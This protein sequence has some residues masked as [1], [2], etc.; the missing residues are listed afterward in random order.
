LSEEVRRKFYR[1]WYASKKRKAFTKYVNKYRG[2][3]KA[4]KVS[5]DEMKRNGC[6]IRV[7]CHTQVRLVPGL[8]GKKPQLME[9]EVL[10]G[11]I[12]DK[13]TF[14]LNLLEKEVPVDSTF[15]VTDLVDVIAISKGKGTAGVISRWGVTR[16]PRK[17]HRGLRKVACI[18]SWHPSAVSWTVGRT[19]Q[20]GYHHRVE[21]NKNIYRIGKL[22][23][24]SFTGSAEYDLTDKSITPMGGFTRYGIIK[25][26]YIILK[27]SVPGPSRRMV[28]LR[29]SL[30]SQASHE[31]REKTILKFIDTSS[32]FGHGHFQTSLEES[33]MFGL[34]KA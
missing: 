26:D 23:Q 5:L 12:P 34:I 8:K 3:M 10:G 17:T 7:L 27:G 11:S 21:R 30:F 32:K 22:G 4:I 16:L 18:G 15:K 1:N 20:K 6:V 25:N 24:N 2:H 33:N 14:S 28:T 13:I 19:G 31:S 29:C 9:I